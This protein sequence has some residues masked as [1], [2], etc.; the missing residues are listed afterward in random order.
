MT[1]ER[2]ERAKKIRALLFGPRPEGS[3]S[4]EARLPLEDELAALLGDYAFGDVWGREGLP[5]ATR[6]LLTI[7]I[8]TALYRSDQLRLHIDGALNIGVTPEQILETIFH[9]GAYSGAPTA[10]NGRSI[11]HAVFK[12]RGII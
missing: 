5:L 4:D 1:D 3:V 8:L 9:A 10:A 11:A 12:K 7:G 6:S 2:K